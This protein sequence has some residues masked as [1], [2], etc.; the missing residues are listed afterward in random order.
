MF[1]GNTEVLSKEQITQNI[2]AYRQNHISREYTSS[3]LKQ[4][5]IGNI[6]ATKINII[7]KKLR[8]MFYKDLPDVDDMAINIAEQFVEQ[9]YDSV[10]I[11]DKAAVTDAVLK[12]YFSLIDDKYAFYRTAE[13]YAQYMDSLKGDSTF[14]GIGVVINSVTLEI[15]SVYDDSPADKAGILPGDIIFGVGDVTTETHQPQE[16]SSL[17]KGEEGTEVTVT[18]IR[19]GEKIDIT[20]I[21]ET[22]LQK[23]VTYR[24]DQDNQ[25][26]YITITQFLET[27]YDQFKEAADACTSKDVK[28]LVIDVRDNPGGLLGS[29]VNII[30]YIVPDAND[31]MIA[32]YTAAGER[33]AYYTQDGHSIDL[34]IAVLCNG[35]TASAGELFT[36]AMRDFNSMGVID[37]VIV[38]TKTFAKGVV[39]TSFD[40][41]D[42][43]GI[44]FTIGY[45]NPP[46]D[47][48]YDGIGIE[49]DIVVDR[50]DYTTDDQLSKAVEAVLKLV[51]TIGGTV[52]ISLAA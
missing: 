27:T 4:L 17:I 24:I 39:Q 50:T 45:Y 52:G 40:I 34:P 1:D 8:E 20:A 43:S 42:G 38:G 22:V 10:D 11:G 47:V 44:T 32:C 48:N 3:H 19:N 6:N 5:G 7:E 12:C 2:E 16:V 51:H 30:D 29:V 14:V 33:Q 25:I 28:A 35:N 36:A 41:S 37:S 49:P 21:R 13:E 15:T 18:I 9:Y 26:G 46:S 31:R 23:S